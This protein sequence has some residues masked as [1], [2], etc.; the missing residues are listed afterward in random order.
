MKNYYLDC[1][2]D[3]LQKMIPE[4]KWKLVSGFSEFFIFSGIHFSEF[5]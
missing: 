1:I 4:A 3:D 2:F 5:I